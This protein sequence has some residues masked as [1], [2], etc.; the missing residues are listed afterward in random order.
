[1]GNLGD[2]KAVPTLKE[3]VVPGKPIETRQSAIYSLARLQKGDKQLTQQ[4]AS[5]LNERSAP[6]KFAVI[7]GLG[8]RGDTAAVPA[9]EELLK[10][11]DLSIEM[12]PMIKGQIARLKR[13]PAKKPTGSA[14]DEGEAGGEKDENV[15]QRLERMEKLLQEMSA[16]M[17]AM[18]NRLP[19][20]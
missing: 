10:S 16:R 2:D 17:K 3:W 14:E 4:L 20:K 8:E 18:E 9:L 15:A 6:L 12:T 13:G 1:M 7:F 5:Y 19:P 11:D